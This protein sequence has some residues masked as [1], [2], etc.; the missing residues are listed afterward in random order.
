MN[1]KNMD[2]LD[3]LAALYAGRRLIVGGGLLICVL[4]LGLSYLIPN[5]YEGYVQIFPPKETKQGFGFA[6]LL[7]D[8]P[9]PSLRLGE[10]GTPADIFIATLKS[11]TTRRR[12]VRE[13]RLMQQY[14]VELVSDAI[15]ILKQK[16][17]IEKSEEGTIQVVVLDQSTEQAAQMAEFYLVLLDSTNKSLTQSGARDRLDFIQRLLDRENA[18]LGDVMETLQK[19]QSANNAISIE[20]QARAVINAA[21]TMQMEAMNLMMTRNAMLNS[22]LSATHPDVRGLQEQINQRLQ[23]LTLLRDGENLVEGAPQV[24]PSLMKDDVRLELAENLFLPLRQIPE[25]ALEYANIEKEVLVQKALMQMLLQQEAEALIEASNTTST[26]QVLDHAVPAEVHARPRRL[27]IVFV[28]GILSLFSS[29]AYTLG[30]V[31][32][33]DLRRRWDSEHS[34]Q[35]AS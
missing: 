22:G 23:A 3:L 1:D 20:D 24:T 21:A 11:P 26:V 5:E 12:M 10:K 27:L 25:V 35:V 8:L 7:A 30:V 18:K 6:D 34:D 16:T 32:V 4:A 28:A 29:V 14:D 2:I 9:I 33:R 31:Y 17:T 15:E 13:F 19:F